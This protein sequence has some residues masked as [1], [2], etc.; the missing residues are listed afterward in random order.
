MMFKSGVIGAIAIAPHVKVIHCEDGNADIVTPDSGSSNR[1]IVLEDFSGLLTIDM[2]MILDTNEGM[3]TM[4]TIQ[5]P[6]LVE[7]DDDKE[8]EEAAVEQ[9]KDKKAATRTRPPIQC[10]G[11]IGALRIIPY[12][13]VIDQEDGKAEISTPRSGSSHGQIVLENFTGALTVETIVVMDPH[14]VQTTTIIE[15]PILVASD[16][17]EGATAMK[18]GNRGKNG[19]KK[20]SSGTPIDSSGAADSVK[21]PPALPTLEES[22]DEVSIV[23]GN[24]DS[25]PAN[26]DGNDMSN[27]EIEDDEEEATNYDTMKRPELWAVYKARL[28]RQPQKLKMREIVKI[29]RAYDDA[30][31]IKN[32]EKEN[33]VNSVVN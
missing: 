3:A 29:L 5:R 32:A 2:M 10:N 13:N 33:H 21:K 9:G 18:Q 16:D 26:P 27:S 12:V 1:H 30:D 24:V 4:A 22:E 14:D 6:A 15:R 23:M 8:E 7:S 17:N 20:T 19:R 31:K 28:G 11:A 25:E